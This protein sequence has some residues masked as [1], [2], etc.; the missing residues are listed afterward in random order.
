MY[1]PPALVSCWTQVEVLGADP[2]GVAGACRVR[3]CPT[4]TLVF[5]S[6][7]LNELLLPAACKEGRPGSAQPGPASAATLPPACP[8]SE[9]ADPHA[10]VQAVNPGLPRLRGNTS[11]RCGKALRSSIDSASL[12]SAFQAVLEGDRQSHVTHVQMLVP[13][14]SPDRQSCRHSAAR[15]VLRVGKAVRGGSLRA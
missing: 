2:G 7:I 4:P 13:A 10:A 6:H 15:L 12:G 5:L 9:Q 1:R 14:S 11:D 3:G 8:L